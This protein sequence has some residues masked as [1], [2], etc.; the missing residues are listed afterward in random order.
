MHNVGL[1]R[2]NQGRGAGDHAPEISGYLAILCFEKRRSPKKY[3]SPPKVKRFQPPK[4]LAPQNSFGC[5]RHWI[6][7]F[8]FTKVDVEAIQTSK[9]YIIQN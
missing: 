9:I 4:Y 2:R 1:H 5:L 8:K 7:P 3:C 6:Q